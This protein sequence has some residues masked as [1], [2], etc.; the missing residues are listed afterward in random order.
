[1]RI[2][3]RVKFLPLGILVASLVVPSA[4]GQCPPVPEGSLLPSGEIARVNLA[5]R[6]GNKLAA[7]LPVDVLRAVK[8]TRQKTRVIADTA[9]LASNAR[10][11]LAKG[12]TTKAIPVKEV[13][14]AGP[15]S[16]PVPDAGGA[17]TIIEQDGRSII[18]GGSDTFTGQVGFEQGLFLGEI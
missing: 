14:F 10:L 12:L 13:G 4:F 8:L 2:V 11:A 6:N 15:V 5:T 3:S 1:M 18:V 7:Q 9:V 17:S 16:I